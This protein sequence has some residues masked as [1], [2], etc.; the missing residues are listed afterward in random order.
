[1]KK[2]KNY[3]KCNKCGRLYENTN[4]FY[5]YNDNYPLIDYSTDDALGEQLKH[6]DRPTIKP[7]LE[8]LK[9]E[10]I[11]PACVPHCPTCSSNRIKKIS[12]LKRATSLY[13]FGFFSKTAISQF[14]CENCGYKW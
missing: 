3:K 6:F 2:M 9:K 4:I 8:S 10:S 14:Q 1:M 13:L 11:N 7:T 12:T 5:C